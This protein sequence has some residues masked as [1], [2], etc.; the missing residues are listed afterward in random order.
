MWLRFIIRL[1]W[2]WRRLGS[3]VCG[4]GLRDPRPTLARRQLL[5]GARLRGGGVARLPH[6]GLRGDGRLVGVAAGTQLRSRRPAGVTARRHEAVH[7]HR[8]G[9]LRRMQSV[10]RCGRCLCPAAHGDIQAIAPI[11][12]PIEL[13]VVVRMS[14][15]RRLYMHRMATIIVITANGTVSPPAH[16]IGSQWVQTPRHGDPISTTSSRNSRY[17][18]L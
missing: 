6:R 13:S 4:S 18:S 10:Q 9:R 7:T 15:L 17:R 11:G 8:S 2:P 5:R 16:M 14:S 1:L 3:L 12:T